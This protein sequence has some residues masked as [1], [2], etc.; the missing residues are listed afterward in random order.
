MGKCIVCDNGGFFFSV[1]Q[2]SICS[3]CGPRFYKRIDK[4]TKEIEYATLAV[5]S[6]GNHLSR[7]KKCDKI[8]ELLHEAETYKIIGYDGFTINMSF[9]R[10]I[11]DIQSI[12]DELVQ[13]HQDAEAAKRKRHAFTFEIDKGGILS[14]VK[15]NTPEGD[16]TF[17][18]LYSKESKSLMR[19]RRYVIRFDTS[20]ELVIR[21][22]V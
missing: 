19:K 8:V 22:V 5:N 18:L 11:S 16:L 20:Y 2:H 4:I 17:L 13:E 6:S 12:R 9:A 14:K 21:R 3:T 7:I 10:G 15:N 1:D